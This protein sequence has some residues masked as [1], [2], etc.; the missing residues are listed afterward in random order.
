MAPYAFCFFSVDAPLAFSNP[1]SF[2]KKCVAMS[3]IGNARAPME[4]NVGDRASVVCLLRALYSRIS[5]SDI[6]AIKRYIGC[7]RVV[8]LQLRIYAV[9]DQEQLATQDS[10]ANAPFSWSQEDLAEDY[11]GADEQ[12][13]WPLDAPSSWAIEDSAVTPLYSFS[14]RSSDTTV[15]P[16]DLQEIQH[17]DAP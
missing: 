8:S 13:A 17:W 6:E 16:E 15:L 5:I 14:S 9:E 1:R 11:T 12:F 4:Y 7:G 2:V 3:V 10:E